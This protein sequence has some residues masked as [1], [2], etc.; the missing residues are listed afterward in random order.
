M[1]LYAFESRPA[2]LETLD[3]RGLRSKSM[4]YDERWNMPFAIEL[5]REK[6]TNCMT[7]QHFTL[8]IP[9][10]GDC[11]FRDADGRYTL[12]PAGS[13]SLLIPGDHT[14]RRATRPVRLAHLVVRQELIN[15]VFAETADGDPQEL[16]SFIGFEDHAWSRDIQTYANRA[17]TPD[18]P[19]THAEMDGRAYVIAL[20]LVRAVS[21]LAHHE[22]RLLEIAETQDL[23]PL[24]ELIDARIREPLRLSTLA[25]E[26]GMSPFHFGRLFKK[27]LGVTPGFYITQRR[28]KQAAEC[29]RGTDTPL[30]DI[31]TDLG[32][33]SQSHMTQQ[34]KR[35]FGTTPAAMRREA[36]N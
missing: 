2:L 8:S 22:V 21:S 4:G 1:G 30:A 14:Q 9:L 31:A 27:Q 25:A 16:R 17:L 32:Y 34:V 20:G 35:H 12:A 28:A 33:S 29:I 5:V 18:N 3:A 19:P 10:D 23:R 6:G 11:S 13:V 26:V 24:L 15:E 36:P 7:G